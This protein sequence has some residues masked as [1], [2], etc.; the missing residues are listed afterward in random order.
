MT[1]ARTSPKRNDDAIVLVPGIGG[2][3]LVAR[4][5][6]RLWGLPAAELVRALYD[7]AHLSRMRVDKAH[8]DDGIKPDGLVR[9]AIIPGLWGVEPYGDLLT[10]VG[11]TVATDK[12]AVISFSYDWRRS[13]AEAAAELG[14]RAR[15]HLRDWQRAGHA[16][17]RLT[18]VCHSMGGLVARYFVDVLGGGE[19]VRRVITLGTPFWGAVRAFQALDTGGILPLGLGKGHL[20]DLLRTLPSVYELLPQYACVDLGTTTRCLEDNDLPRGC[21]VEL[22]HA[23]R[24]THAAMAAKTTRG[25]TVFETVAGVNQ[26]TLQSLRF[27]NRRSTRYMTG[28]GGTNYGGDGSVYSL[29][30][31][32]DTD[33]HPSLHA[34]QQLASAKDAISLLCWLAARPPGARAPLPPTLGAGAPKLEAPDS[35]ILGTPAT[36]TVSTDQDDAVRY[37]VVNLATDT[38]ELRGTIDVG[39]SPTD[40]DIYLPYAGV[41]RV[42]VV[43]GGASPVSHT[44]VGLPASAA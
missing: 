23:A 6:T 7:E 39:P 13:V 10:R 5:G 15:N 41:F 40:V 34:H 30:A 11:S 21:D 38:P 25:D 20:R 19:I 8:P 44:L 9:F 14:K 27:R 18:L 33:S 29:A 2:S 17:A 16:D 28:I 37:T 35:S 32:L 43:A 42:D 22:L 3:A 36:L 1:R 4:D 24:R 26:P 31:T 12:H